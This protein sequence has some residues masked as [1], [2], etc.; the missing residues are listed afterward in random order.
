MLSSIITK[1]WQAYKRAAII[2]P[3]LWRKTEK[4]FQ[5]GRCLHFPGVM[6]IGCQQLTAVP[7][8]KNCLLMK[9]PCQEM[10]RRVNPKTPRCGLCERMTDIGGTS[11]LKEEP[12]CHVISAL[13]QPV[14]QAGV[15]CSWTHIFPL[16]LSFSSSCLLHLQFLPENLKSFAKKSSSQALFLWNPAYTT[17]L[18][19]WVVRFS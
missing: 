8:L 16:L 3:I 14:D 10:P 19:H 7:S 1:F 9:L 2:S 13:Q 11:C 17:T 6:S 4:I 5:V 12:F 18:L 15:D